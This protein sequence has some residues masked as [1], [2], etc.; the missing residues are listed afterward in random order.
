MQALRSPSG[1]PLI[2]SR[3]REDA[4]RER[5]AEQARWG[6]GLSALLYLDLALLSPELVKAALGRTSE[7]AGP[8]AIEAAL[9]DFYLFTP[10]HLALLFLWGASL[11]RNGKWSLA[12]L[13]AALFLSYL[14]LLPVAAYLFD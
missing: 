10:L 11:R 13:P 4:R 14:L 12:G 6:L 1:G 5:L 9:F 8:E 2:P 3:W 7:T